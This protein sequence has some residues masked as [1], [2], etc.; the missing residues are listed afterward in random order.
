MYEILKKRQPVGGRQ[1]SYYLLV[2]EG[3]ERPLQYGVRIEAE[4][5]DFDE[6]FAVTTSG[7]RMNDLLELL[8][9]N[10]VT[11]VSLGDIIEDW[12]GC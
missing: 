6:V 7:Q 4:G 11:P 8:I 9:R 10:A 2:E 3:R 1:I 5:G 12:L